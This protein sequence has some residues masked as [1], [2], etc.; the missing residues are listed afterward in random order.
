MF[1][2]FTT[3]EGLPMD[4]RAN[5]IQAFTGTEE[6]ATRIFLSGAG[7]LICERIAM[8]LQEG[9]G[10]GGECDLVILP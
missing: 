7:L 3:P 10:C 4:I 1:V 6:G 5:R 8:A 9:Q 2:R